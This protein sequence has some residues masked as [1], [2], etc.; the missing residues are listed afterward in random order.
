MY[1]VKTLPGQDR[2]AIMAALGAKG[3]PTAVYYPMPLHQQTAYR[4]FPH[5]PAGLPSSED[6]SRRVFSLP[7][8]PYLDQAT[9][10]VII[11]AV[12]AAVGHTPALAE[13]AAG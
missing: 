2:E 13:A 10:Q 6:L 5:D 1:T 3:V 7:M 11:D 8:H 12:L 4:D 9:H